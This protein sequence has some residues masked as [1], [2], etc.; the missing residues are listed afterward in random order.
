MIGIGQERVCY[1]CNTL[2]MVWENSR[3]VIEFMKIP[4]AIR[5]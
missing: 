2:L 3:G 4:Q 5:W 1:V